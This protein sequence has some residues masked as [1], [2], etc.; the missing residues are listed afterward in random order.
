M[1]S[2]IKKP[3][4]GERVKTAIRALKGYLI[5]DPPIKPTVFPAEMLRI[6]KMTAKASYGWWFAEISREEKELTLRQDL[7]RELFDALMNAGII[8]IS[9][10]DYIPER[11][12]Y[13]YRAEIYFVRHENMEGRV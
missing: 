9:G 12:E 11:G 10:G 13:E 6:E 1:V 7:R 5:L 4:F 3:A 8:K 2:P